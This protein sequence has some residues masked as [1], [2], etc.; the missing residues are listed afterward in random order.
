M[1][2]I[3]T[4]GIDL[5]KNVFAAH[6]VGVAGKSALVRPSVPRGK[7]LEWIAALPPLPHGYGSLL[8]RPPLGACVPEV[9]PHRAPDGAQVRGA[10]PAFRQAS[11]ERCRRCRGH[12]K[13]RGP[14]QHAFLAM[15]YG[16]SA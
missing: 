9:Q 14:P 5:A 3:V 15:K 8:R 1:S 10:L 4:I 12:L 13:G 16:S 7:L 2:A 6:G 11:Q